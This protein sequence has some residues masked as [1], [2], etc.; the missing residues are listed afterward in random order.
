MTILLGDFLPSR[1]LIDA[2]EWFHAHIKDTV[3]IHAVLGDEPG[4]DLNP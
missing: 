2:S 3:I 1:K 4:M